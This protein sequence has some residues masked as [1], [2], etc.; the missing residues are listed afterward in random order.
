[1]KKLLAMILIAVMAVSLVACA[2][3]QP[4]GTNSGTHVHKVMEGWSFNSTHHWHECSCGNYKESVAAH[5]GGTATCTDMAICDVC[6]HA[7]GEML[8]HTHGT[9]WLS[10]E[11]AHWNECVCGDKANTSAHADENADEKCD[12]CEYA[13]PIAKPAKKGCKSVLSV[14]PAVLACLGFGVA[15]ALKKKKN[16]TK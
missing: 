13:M 11:N 16:D 10:D 9:A 1:M 3:I 5:T 8:P 15:V 4:G 2:P 12:A 7:Y 14:T 6:K